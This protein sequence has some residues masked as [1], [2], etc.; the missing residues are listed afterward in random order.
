MHQQDSQPGTP[1]HGPESG[2]AAA[3]PDSPAEAIAIGARVISWHEDKTVVYGGLPD[4][5][6]IDTLSWDMLGG[7]DPVVRCDPRRVAPAGI[8]IPA[9]DGRVTAAKRPSAEKPF[10]A[11]GTWRLTLPGQAPSWYRT[12]RDATTAGLRQIAILD[13]H[14]ARPEAAGN[15]LRDARDPL[16]EDRHLNR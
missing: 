11:A 12:K 9:R 16:Q 10:G 5:G 15:A 3:R 6:G 2:P 4:I 1:A 13:W 8:P 7:G 14:A